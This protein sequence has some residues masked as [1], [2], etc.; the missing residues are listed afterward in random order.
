MTR[1]YTTKSRLIFAKTVDPPPLTFLKLF[2]VNVRPIVDVGPY[3]R[4]RTPELG[5]HLLWA[6]LQASTVCKMTT[7]SFLRTNV[8]C[9]STITPLDVNLEVVALNFFLRPVADMV[10]NVG[11]VA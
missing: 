2:G 7:N 6:T 8:A 5:F 10:G 3:H 4:K 9:R 1:G 11:P